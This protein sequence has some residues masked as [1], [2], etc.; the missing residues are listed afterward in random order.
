MS[1]ND[2]WLKVRISTWSWCSAF[3]M[4]MT[5]VAAWSL[6]PTS[7][8]RI[9]APDSYTISGLSTAA[10]ENIQPLRF[11]PMRLPNL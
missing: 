6:A 1:L 4:V 7:D 8:N 5:P 10:L 3:F 2:R 9:N 11:A